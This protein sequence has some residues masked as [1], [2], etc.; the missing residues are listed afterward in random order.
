MTEDEDT[1]PEDFWNKK[2][3]I[4]LLGFAPDKNLG[5]RITVQAHALH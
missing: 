3:V 1:A 2:I 5:V 4:E